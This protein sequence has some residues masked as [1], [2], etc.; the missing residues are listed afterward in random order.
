MSAIFGF[1]RILSGA[2][3]MS[4]PSLL[5]Q[6]EAE[7]LSAAEFGDSDALRVGDTVVAIGP[8]AKKLFIIFSYLTLILVVAAFAP[9]MPSAIR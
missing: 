1:E 6:I 8:K 5:K 2:K 3:R 7:G 4:R 9:W